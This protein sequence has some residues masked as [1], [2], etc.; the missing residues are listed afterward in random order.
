MEIITETHRAQ[1]IIYLCF[2]H[3]TKLLW[4]LENILCLCKL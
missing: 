1:Q 3:C 2:F 4:F